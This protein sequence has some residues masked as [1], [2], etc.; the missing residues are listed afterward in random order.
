M[1]LERRKVS[2]FALHLTDTKYVIERINYANLGHEKE[3]R[4]GDNIQNLHDELMHYLHRC[5]RNV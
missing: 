4:N 1:S 3:A 5:V 2:R